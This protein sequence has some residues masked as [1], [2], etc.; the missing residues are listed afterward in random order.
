MALGGEL[1]VNTG[2]AVF[3]VTMTG[4]VMVPCGLLESVAVTLTV[5]EPT[6]VGVPVIWQFAPSV[7]PGEASRS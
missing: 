4:A 3:T 6:T 7:S 1:G 2:V 5:G